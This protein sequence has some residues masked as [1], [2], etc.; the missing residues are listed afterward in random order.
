MILLSRDILFKKIYRYGVR[1]PN[2]ELIKSYF[3]GRDQ[4]VLYNN[5]FSDIRAQELGVIQGSKN[6]PLF[7]DIYS[8]DI[9]LICDETEN[10]HY[11]DDTCLI[12]VGNNLSSL[13][14]HVNDRLK[15]ILDRCNCNKLSLNP[16]KSELIIFTN[17]PIDNEPLIYLGSSQI[18]RKSTVK[19][20]GLNIDDNLKFNSHLT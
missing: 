15:T 5:Y 1:G 6:G 3:T 7:Y 17:K 8:S 16:S 12:Y 19:Y 14:A 10:I 9:N 18:E 11:A 4:H 13:T 20:L 2:L